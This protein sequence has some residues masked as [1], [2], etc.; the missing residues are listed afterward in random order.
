[1]SAATSP[2][3]RRG[4]RVRPRPRIPQQ[5]HQPHHRGLR[6]GHSDDRRRRHHRVQTSAGRRRWRGAPPALVILGGVPD[7]PRF[8]GP[9]ARGRRRPAR[10]L[11]AR[12]H[13]ADP[14]QRRDAHLEVQLD[15]LDQATQDA[16]LAALRAQARRLWRPGGTGRAESLIRRSPSPGLSVASAER[17]RRR[18]EAQRAE[19]PADGGHAVGHPLHRRTGHFSRCSAA[20]RSW[21]PSAI[22]GGD[23]GRADRRDPRRAPR[24]PT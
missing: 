20:W 2:S 15:R 14:E 23:S 19:R 12:L 22:E 24:A 3:R 8:R 11:R 21:N 16:L 5:R 17:L 18:R 10:G 1:M 4:G 6:R 9:A 13:R 7:S